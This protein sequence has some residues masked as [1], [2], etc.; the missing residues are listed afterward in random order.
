MAVFFGGLLELA[1]TDLD[2]VDFVAFVDGA[3]AGL[4]GFDF[5][6]LVGVAAS[7]WEMAAPMFAGEDFAAAAAE[8]LIFVCRL[9]SRAF[10]DPMIVAVKAVSATK[11]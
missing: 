6:A 4:I 8:K 11:R 10:L 1:F 3:V 5:G 7:D 9:R 2:D